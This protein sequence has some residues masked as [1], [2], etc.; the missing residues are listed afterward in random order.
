M[1]MLR[2]LF[3]SYWRS[4]RGLCMIHDVPMEEVPADEFG[5]WGSYVLVCPICEREK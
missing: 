1:R 5:A 3:K 2:A 4:V